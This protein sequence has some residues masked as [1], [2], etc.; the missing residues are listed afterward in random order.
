MT[1]PRSPS[2]PV[3]SDPVPIDSAI[4]PG[5]VPTSALAALDEGARAIAGVL[6]V[7]FVLQLIADR[8]RTL[9]GARYAALGIARPDG[10][11][12]RFI[13]SGISAEQRAA[14]GPLPVGHGLLGLIIKEGRSLRIP[15]MADHPLGVGFPPQ[16]P[17]MTSFLG[18]PV[19]AHGRPIGN[20]YLTDKD[21]G[22]EFTAADQRL[23]EM[24]ALHAGIAI[25][26]ARLHAQVRGL[27]V[28]EERDR[29]SR[30]L[31]DGI[32]Q[33]LY[34]VSLSLEDVLTMPAAEA[35][36]RVDQAIDA[37]HL[38]IRDIRHFIHGLSGEATDGRN[39]PAGLLALANEVRHNT[40][41]EVETSIDRG[42]DPGLTPEQGGQLL[43]L[44]REA[45]S[46]AARHA[47]A[48]RIELHLAGD[49]NRATV[50]IADD[51]TGFDPDASA[52]PG[53]RGLANMRSRSSELGAEL[54]IR[55]RPGAGTRVTVSVPR[56]PVP[57]EG[58][59]G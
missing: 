42:A 32:I 12:E 3:R 8:V 33:S 59:R 41:V 10:V 6:D 43:Q 9:V 37:L 49:A 44:V 5:G 18:V 24:F 31:H 52:A 15:D 2:A 39:L 40:L 30:D 34:G 36:A 20:F 46:N 11:M 51:G 26:N 13:T 35:E 48:T 27:A 53:H 58:S 50:E 55:S 56:A 54:E 45:L 21:G 28:V 23:A 38:A 14:I 47:R 19:T 4:F 25:D 17:P 7:E 22:A 57:S 16:H 1:V 29:I